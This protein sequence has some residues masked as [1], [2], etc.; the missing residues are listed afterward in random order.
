MCEHN[1]FVA[2]IDVNRIL[3]GQG[4]ISSFQADI[5]IWCAECELPFQFVGLPGGLNMQGAAVSLD[6]LEARLTIKPSEL[7][8]WYKPDTLKP[9]R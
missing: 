8:A 6:E 4:Q 3:N 9:L 1:D 7:P 2:K 5:H